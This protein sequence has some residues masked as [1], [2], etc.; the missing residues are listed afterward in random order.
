MSNNTKCHVHQTARALGLCF[1]AGS[2]Y[3]IQKGVHIKFNLLWCFHRLH[4]NVYETKT[5]FTLS[6]VSRTCC[7][8]LSRWGVKFLCKYLWCIACFCCCRFWRNSSL[9]YPFSKSIFCFFPSFIKTILSKRTVSLGNSSVKF[10]PAFFLAASGT[11]FGTLHFLFLSCF[12]FAFVSGRGV[13]CS[14]SAFVTGR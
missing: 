3:R 12:N 14:S 5:E 7:C 11:F 4:F 6:N 13:V 8:I 10:F 2:G 9:G 1:D